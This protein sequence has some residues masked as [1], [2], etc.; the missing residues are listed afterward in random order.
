MENPKPHRKKIYHN[1][2]NHTSIPIDCILGLLAKLYIILEN[3][4]KKYAIDAFC[5]N[6]WL[7]YQFI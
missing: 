5:F 4:F 1:Q 7:L 6:K 3:Q 2:G